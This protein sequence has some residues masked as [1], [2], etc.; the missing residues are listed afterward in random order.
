MGGASE[1]D[2]D[3]AKAA[4]GYKLSREAKPLVDPV[5]QAHCDGLTTETRELEAVLWPM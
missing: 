1:S 3:V 4:A 2:R 5:G